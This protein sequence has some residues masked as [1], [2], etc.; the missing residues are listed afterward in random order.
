MRYLRQSTAVSVLLGPLVDDADG[1]TPETAIN[2]AATDLDFYKG[3]T[4]SDIT[5][6]DSGGSNDWAHVANGFYS[7]ELTISDTDTLGHFR[8]SVNATGCLP[9]WEDF[10]VLPAN[11]YDSLVLGTD[12]LQIDL[13]QWGGD[14]PSA[15]VSGT[16]PANATLI[17]GLDATG[18]IT[19]AVPTADA[20]ANTV[21]AEELPGSYNPGEAGYIVGHNLDAQVSDIIGGPTQTVVVGADDCADV[22]YFDI[23]ERKPVGARLAVTS[24]TFTITS[25]T[26]TLHAGSTALYGINAVGATG[27]DAGALMAPRAWYS[28]DTVTPPSGG[29][30]AAGN[31]ELVFT[32]VGTSS[33]GLTRTIEVPIV[34]SVS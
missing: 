21:W 10:I 31:Y 11:V 18:Q 29:P 22:Q 23:G 34:I 4:K 13:R 26:V 12:L 30:I 14:L 19:S 27:F 28:L 17:E 3:I 5:D 25:V 32:F 33:D 7:L 8:I 16:V 9:T 24:G 6:T 20:V 15:L 1:K 2:A